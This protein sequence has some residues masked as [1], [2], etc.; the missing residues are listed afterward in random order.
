MKMGA[1]LH[2]AI[3]EP[4]R[5]QAEAM[6]LWLGEEG[7]SY[8]CCDDSDEFIACLEKVDVDFLVLDCQFAGENCFDLM[9]TVTGM[10]ERRVPVLVVSSPDSD[11]DLLE[12]LDHGADDFMIKPLQRDELLARIHLMTRRFAR[13]YPVVE[14]ETETLLVSGPFVIDFSQRQV[15]RN[16]EE[17]LLTEKDFNLAA[18][19]FKHL[20]QLLSRDRLLEDVWG[21]N[22]A[23]NTRTVDM[24][25]SRL[26]KALDLNGT[27]YEIKT[28]HHQGYR[29]QT[30]L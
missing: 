16:G 3:L 2:I 15:T 10:G 9:L 24:H 20:D 23:V 8:T 19:M 21:V 26:R 30:I 7:Y 13:E 12:V 22:Q 5:R 25:I 27:G 11:C 17:V 29:L 18:Y 28:V 14:Q 1:M 6:M 4:D